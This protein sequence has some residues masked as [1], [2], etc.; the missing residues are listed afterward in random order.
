[1]LRAFA[2][3]SFFFLSVGCSHFG[4]SQAEKIKNSLPQ[5]EVYGNSQATGKT[6]T[7]KP[8]KIRV[9]HVDDQIKDGVFIPAHL[10]YEILEQVRWEE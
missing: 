1:M 2:F 4:K 10:E 5:V 3:L 9:R 7:L 6:P 8:P